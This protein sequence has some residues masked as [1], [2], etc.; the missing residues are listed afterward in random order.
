MRNTITRTAIKSKPKKLLLTLLSRKGQ[1]PLMKTLQSLPRNK[2]LKQ[3]D[4]FIEYS[5]LLK[6]QNPNGLYDYEIDM[7]SR[8]FRSEA[9]SLQDFC[10]QTFSCI[11]AIISLDAYQ[12]FRKI[13]EAPLSERS[14][15]KDMTEVKVKQL[16]TATSEI[17]INSADTLK[18]FIQHLDRH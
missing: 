4:Q 16:G 6:S 17:K 10:E 5:Y 14:L 12:D 3:K 8:R 7:L 1:N 11:Y 15:F 9:L 13:I 18:Q 2:L